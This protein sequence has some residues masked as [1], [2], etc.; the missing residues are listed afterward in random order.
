PASQLWKAFVQGPS[1]P[2]AAS[3]GCRTTPR[4]LPP[5]RQYPP[6]TGGPILREPVSSVYSPAGRNVIAD[7]GDPARRDGCLYATARLGV[8]TG[9]LSHHSGGHLLSR[10]Q[11]ARHGDHRDSTARAAIWTDPGTQPD[12]FH[13]LGRL[14][15]H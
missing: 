5:R 3:R 4:S 7:G 1:W 9:R 14:F 13:E 6:A 10:R 15:G 8:A 11:S 2:P 12:D